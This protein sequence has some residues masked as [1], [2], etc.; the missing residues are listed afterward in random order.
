MSNTLYQ[1]PRLTKGKGVRGPDFYGC[2]NTGMA[3]AI[4]HSRVAGRYLVGPELYITEFEYVFQIFKQPRKRKFT[5]DN[6]RVVHAF[7]TRK[8]AV[9]LFQQLAAAA[10]AQNDKIAE[11]H[12][13]DLVA[14]RSGDL[15]AASRLLDY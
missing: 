1:V 13:S 7:R 8:A 6:G 9:E 10:K 2:C 4:V 3:P 14:A 15:E 11:Q 5:F 12:K